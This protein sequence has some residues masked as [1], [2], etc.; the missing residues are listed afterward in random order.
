MG[1]QL[2]TVIGNGTK[3]MPNLHDANLMCMQSTYL[4]YSEIG[5]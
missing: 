1:I 5:W 2:Y 4:K 3:R